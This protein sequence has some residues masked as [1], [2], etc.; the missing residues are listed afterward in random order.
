MTAKTMKMISSQNFLYAEDENQFE[1]E[2]DSFGGFF[3]QSISCI[4]FLTARFLLK[5]NF[6]R[7]FF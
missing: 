6:I 4:V 7:I 1:V 3:E 2:F 5:V